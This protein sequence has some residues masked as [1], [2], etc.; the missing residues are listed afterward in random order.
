MKKN[1]QN[2]QNASERPADSISALSVQG[3]SVWIDYITRDLVRGGGLKKLIQ[4]DGLCGET[5]NPTIFQKAISG[6]SSYDDQIKQ[7]AGQGKSAAEIFEAL[8]VKDIQEACDLFR[9]VYDHLEGADGF[10]SIEVVPAV[11]HDAQAT[12]LEARRLWQSVQR[13]NL[14]VK[15]P[16]TIEGAVAVKQLLKE[17]ININITLLFSVQNHERVMWAYIEALE[18]R[19]AAG[20]PVNRLASVASYFVSRVD[21]LVDKLLEDKIKVTRDSLAQEELRRLSG[22]VGIANAKLAYARFREI[23]D[24][25]RVTKLRAQGA[26]VQRPLW[27]STSTKNP[28]FSDVMYVEALIGPDT[29]NTVPQETFDAFKDHGK[30]RR[31]VDEHMNEARN[32]ISALGKADIDYA[33][34]TA[35]LETEG[36]DKFAK[37]YDELLA[38]VDKKRQSLQQVAH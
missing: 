7:L 19:L 14:M 33:A 22:K 27:A 10:V 23:F 38:D 21:T 2:T 6:S 1:R 3:Q 11:A 36:I 31:T 9:P 17:G 28:A 24:G 35:Q 32:I 18:E 8:A 34:M 15:V 13:P 30:V 25:E 5:S 20:Q 37:S 26:R 16:G 4:E 29:I 12:I